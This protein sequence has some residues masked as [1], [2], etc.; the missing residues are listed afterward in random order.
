MPVSSDVLAQVNPATQR[1]EF[2]RDGHEANSERDFEEVMRQQNEKQDQ[3]CREA[4]KSKEP[5]EPQAHE[6]ISTTE[7]V[8]AEQ[9]TEASEPED[10]A[11]SA[12]SATD[13]EPSE[14]QEAAPPAAS[15]E[16]SGDEQKPEGLLVQQNL[17][18]DL[19]LGGVAQAAVTAP[20]LAVEAVKMPLG[21]TVGLISQFQN[22]KAVQTKELASDKVIVTKQDAQQSKIALKSAPKPVLPEATQKP[23]IK[24]SAPNATLPASTPIAKGTS[25]A[26]SSLNLSSGRIPI[27]MFQATAVQQTLTV[28]DPSQAADRARMVEAI[29]RAGG[30]ELRQLQGKVLEL[31]LNPPEL[32]RIQIRA[33]Q[34]GSEMIL[35]LSVESSEAL[36]LFKEILPGLEFSLQQRLEEQV[37]VELNQRDDR[38]LLE[39]QS[40]DGDTKQSLEE[41]ENHYESEDNSDEQPFQP[42]V[43]GSTVQVLA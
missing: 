37:E 19:Q 30:G 17:T 13:D 32:G 34:R 10:S 14:E 4:E 9:A 33:E 18:P 12:M 28:I 16:P 6:E 26:Q 21:E 2:D 36:S 1:V 7:S 35:R 11:D 29:L 40:Q 3:A 31:R 41:N 8:E 42:I 5:E 25:P 43:D 15:E 20:D 38:S 39:E 22:L 27:P 24:A 23:V